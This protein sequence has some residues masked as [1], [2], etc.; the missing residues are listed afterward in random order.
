MRRFIKRPVLAYEVGQRAYEWLVD[1]F[2]I[3]ENVKA[4]LGVYERLLAEA[5][6]N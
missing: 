5:G 4:V 3:E 6:I 2:T 1:K